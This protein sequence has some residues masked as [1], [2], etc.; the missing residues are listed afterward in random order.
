MKISYSDEKFEVKVQ[1]CD[2]EAR[3]WI[4]SFHKIV[5]IEFCCP[6]M[7]EQSVLF[8]RSN[9]QKRGYVVESFFDVPYLAFQYM[10]NV[11]L[12]LR[13]CPQCGAKVEFER[14]Q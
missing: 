2:E 7:Q 3:V 5:D 14:V 6:A 13:C 10:G 4:A 12:H 11:V 8:A 9:T 1:P